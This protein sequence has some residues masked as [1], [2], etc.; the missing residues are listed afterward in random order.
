[1]QNKAFMTEKYSFQN[2]TKRSQGNRICSI[3]IGREEERGIGRVCYLQ[4]LLT[5]N[6]T[7]TITA[8]SP[9]HLNCGGCCG[10]NI[11]TWGFWGSY[12]KIRSDI[13]TMISLLMSAYYLISIHN[14]IHQCIWYFP[15]KTEGQHWKRIFKYIILLT[16]NVGIKASS[17]GTF[18]Y[19]ISFLPSKH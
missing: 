3:P 7:S 19:I 10:N 1:M 14:I 11:Q 9:V 5:L 8:R 13:F 2:I 17:T 6:W 4:E 12:V 15:F 16:R 18:S